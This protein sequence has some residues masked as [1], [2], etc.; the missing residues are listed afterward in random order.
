M[1]RLLLV[2]AGFLFALAALLGFNVVG[3]A[4]TLTV[5]SLVAVGLACY[6]L[7]GIV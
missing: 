3:S 4:S 5:V 1:G 7:A 2:A 6:A